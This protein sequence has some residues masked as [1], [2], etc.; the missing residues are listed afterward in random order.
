MDKAKNDHRGWKTLLL[1]LMAMVLAFGIPVLAVLLWAAGNDAKYERMKPKALEAAKSYLAEQ[2]PGNDFEITEFY[3]NFKDNGFDA[4]IQSRSSADTYFLVRIADDTLELDYDSYEWAVQE[5]W[6]TAVRITE[7]YEAQAEGVLNTLPGIDRADADFV[8]YSRTDSY[9]AFQLAVGLDTTTL[10]LDGT[11][12]AAAMGWEHGTL[13]LR[14]VEAEED[15]NLRRLLERLREVDDAMTQAGVGYRVV[16][17]RLVNAPDWDNTRDFYIY[18]I[19]RE[20]LYSEDPE[21]VLQAL[22]EEQEAKRQ[23]L[24]EQWAQSDN[25]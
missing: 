25:Q 13:E 8:R 2:Y 1:C 18:G 3:H 14:F 4:E 9:S 10:E 22:W 24:K 11:Y 7:D 6:N 23:A 21:A 19:L 5:R 20:D 12:D 16:E 17:I 15:L